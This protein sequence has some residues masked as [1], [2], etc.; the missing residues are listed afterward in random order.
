MKKLVVTSTSV[1]I[2]LLIVL[3]A[4]SFAEDKR[5]AKRMVEDTIYGTVTCTIAPPPPPPGATQTLPDST[6]QCLARHGSIVIIEEPRRD[7]IPIENPD[8]VNGYEGRR[9]SASGYKNGDN[10]HIISVRVI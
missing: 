9:I 10:F 1:A 4:V 2:A 6:K 8:A 3:L 7:A 5:N